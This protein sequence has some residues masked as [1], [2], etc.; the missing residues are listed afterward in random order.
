MN[1]VYR[2]EIWIQ[3]NIFW[4]YKNNSNLRVRTVRIQRWTF[5]NTFNIY[6]RF[7]H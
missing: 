4:E 1:N 6:L 3:G 5:A 7:R 2:N